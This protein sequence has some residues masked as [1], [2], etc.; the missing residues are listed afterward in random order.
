VGRLNTIV[1]ANNVAGRFY[2][3]NIIFFLRRLTC[4]AMLCCKM[5]TEISVNTEFSVTNRT[6]NYPT[7]PSF[8]H[9]S[10]S[11]CHVTKL[12]GTRG[13]LKLYHVC[14]HDTNTILILMG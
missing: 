8:R 3:F 11:I 13:A 10:L 5:T 4:F 2:A 14:G 6:A 7:M 12:G 9:V 1:I